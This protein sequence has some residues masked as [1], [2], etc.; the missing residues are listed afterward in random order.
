MVSKAAKD[1]GTDLAKKYSLRCSRQVGSQFRIEPVDD[2]EKLSCENEL[3]TLINSRTKG[4]TSKRQHV[5]IAYEERVENDSLQ[6][7]KGSKENDSGATETESKKSKWEPNNWLEVL[8]NIREMRRQRDA[9]VDTMGCD[10]CA[11]KSAP[12][13]VNVN[14]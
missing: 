9:P 11:D 8:N 2:K 10:K 1:I 5:S 7:K 13:E 14:Y 4:E 3:L 12:P 6:K